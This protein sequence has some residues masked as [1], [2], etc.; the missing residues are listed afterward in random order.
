MHL[1]YKTFTST[2]NPPTRVFATAMKLRVEI[3]EAPSQA[4]LDNNSGGG[5][6]MNMASDEVK[7]M[8]SDLRV[9]LGL[10]RRLAQYIPGCF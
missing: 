8:E 3:K 5:D 7:Y 10:L 2:P 1:K 4:L 9:E 6:L